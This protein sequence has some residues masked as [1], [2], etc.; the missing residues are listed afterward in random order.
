MIEIASISPTSPNSA[1]L[2]SS[3]R[4]G[5]NTVWCWLAQ[6]RVMAQGT[7]IPRITYR[8]IHEAHLA[9][10]QLAVICEMSCA[11]IECPILWTTVSL[12]QVTVDTTL[13]TIFRESSACREGSDAEG[14]AQERP[15]CR[16]CTRDRRLR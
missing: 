8:Q 1:C 10:I 15:R 9:A 2:K 3:L 13:R 16:A 5:F 11:P 14:E 12:R 4:L 6:A 7:T